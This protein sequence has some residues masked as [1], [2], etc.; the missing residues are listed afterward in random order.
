MNDQFTFKELCLISHCFCRKAEQIMQEFQDKNGY[1]MGHDVPNKIDE[2]CNNLR[3][4]TTVMR[5]TD[6]M[7]LKEWKRNQKQKQRNRANE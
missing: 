4:L 6:D 3:E 2:M 1:L 5:K 7:A